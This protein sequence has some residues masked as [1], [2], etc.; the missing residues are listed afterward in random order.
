MYIPKV[1]RLYLEPYKCNTCRN[2]VNLSGNLNPSTEN[3]YCSVIKKVAMRNDKEQA[4]WDYPHNKLGHVYELCP[5]WHRIDTEI[6]GVH[7][8]EYI[9]VCEHCMDEKESDH[10][11]D[12]ILEE[13]LQIQEEMRME[14]ENF[15]RIHGISS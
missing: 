9:G 4:V 11:F 6:C 15:N 14:L 12:E 7:N 10:I 8:T 2:M 13:N 3:Q 1:D 5:E